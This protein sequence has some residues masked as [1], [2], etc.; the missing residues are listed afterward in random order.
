MSDQRSDAAR[1]YRRWYKKAAWTQGI[2]AR[3]LRA[4]PMC[5]M[6]ASRGQDTLAV[7]VDHI[8]PHRGDRALFFDYANT[9]ALCKACHDR[10]KQR[11]EV[12][13]YATALDEDGWPLD[14]AHP[15]N[16]H[17]QITQP[18]KGD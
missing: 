13:G 4:E 9:Q 3:R 6:C 18:G 17:Q 12:R 7:I 8:V 15:A 2:R 5:R 16:A 11:E 1:V 10:H 14:P